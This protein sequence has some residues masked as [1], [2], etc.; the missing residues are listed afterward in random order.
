MAWLRNGD[1]CHNL[2]PAG[3]LSQKW[4]IV[5]VENSKNQLCGSCRCAVICR[6]IALFSDLSSLFR[7]RI[8][9]AVFLQRFA[10]EIYHLMFLGRAGGEFPCMG[11]FTGDHRTGAHACSAQLGN[12]RDDN[13]FTVSGVCN[14]HAAWR[15]GLRNYARR[16]SVQPAQRY[17]G[18]D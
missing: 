1:G 16:K 11:T 9:M 3:L 15:Q 17:H 13:L 7:V 10:A 4:L 2:L 14:L 5:I 18:Y 6:R 8:C 12:C